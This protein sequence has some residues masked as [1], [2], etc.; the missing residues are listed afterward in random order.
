MAV[1]EVRSTL[2]H[3]SLMQKSKWDL[4]WMVLKQSRE[5]EALD[6][7]ADE[8]GQYALEKGERWRVSEGAEIMD[9]LQAAQE[10]TGKFDTR[11]A[12]KEESPPHR[13]TTQFEVLYHFLVFPI[14]AILISAHHGF[15]VLGWV[16]VFASILWFFLKPSR[17]PAAQDRARELLQNGAY[18]ANAATG[19]SD[20]MR[21]AGASGGWVR[22]QADYRG[23]G[24]G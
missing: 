18:I 24:H 4:A 3:K 20:L 11:F 14:L 7:L 13:G 10:A 16:S 22:E 21:T 5:L 15:P 12:A 19:H 1:F 17:P 9:A 8:V 2:T 23:K 6:Q